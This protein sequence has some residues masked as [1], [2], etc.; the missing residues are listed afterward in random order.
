[1]PKPINK[2]PVL[3]FDPDKH[4]ADAQFLTLAMDVIRKHGCWLGDNFDCAERFLDIDGPD[5]AA[6]LAC[7]EE[8]DDRLS[9]YVVD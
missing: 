7:A 2:Q 1:M 6:M 5:D 8:L 4:K 9:E 3:P